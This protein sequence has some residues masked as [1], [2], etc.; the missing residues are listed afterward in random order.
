MKIHSKLTSLAEIV[1]ENPDW[2]FNIPIYQRLYVWGE[3]QVL[4][5]LNDLANAYERGGDIF[6]L[7]GTLLVEQHVKEG[8]CFDLI[9]GQQRF[10]TLWLLCHA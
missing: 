10:T 1:A 4:T 8:R 5:L 7:G 2:R 3:D 9:D 6:F